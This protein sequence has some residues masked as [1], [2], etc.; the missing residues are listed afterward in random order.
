[1]DMAK[2]IGERRNTLSTLIARQNAKKFIMEAF[3]QGTWFFNDISNIAEFT[4]FLLSVPEFTGNR[5]LEILGFNSPKDLE[6]IEIAENLK[7]VDKN[8][9]F[10]PHSIYGSSPKIYEYVNENRRQSMVSIHL[11]ETEAEREVFQM[12]GEIWNFLESIGQSH[13]PNQMK[14]TGILRYLY[15]LGMLSYK[16]IMLVHLTAANP[17]EIEY[18]SEQS[19]H[20]AWVVCERSNKHLSLERKNWEL[21]LNSPLSM[22][23]GTDSPATSPNL[24]VIKEMNAIQETGK[25]PENR[26]W[27]AATFSAYEHLE[28]PVSQVPYFLF[29]ESKPNIASIANSGKA[30]MLRG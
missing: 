22:L 2:I 12:R 8:V 10:T 19:A 17:L 29:P 6:R 4:G 1:M 11:L 24:S 23:I 30:I 27:Q 9:I 28:I 13:L 25:V 20:A 21:L 18:L 26:I 14:K 5:F 15:E 3:A 7:E 16:K